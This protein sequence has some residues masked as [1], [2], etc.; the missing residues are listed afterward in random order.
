MQLTND[1]VAALRRAVAW[2]KGFARREPQLVV[3]PTPMP[4]EGTPDWIELAQRLAAEAQYTTLGLKP[5]QTEPVHVVDNGHVDPSGWAN[6][7]DEVALRRKMLALG[8]SLFE[9]DV[10]A[11]IARA[12]H[13]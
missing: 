5:W 10:P 3:F 13:R 11:A 4:D 7:P 9:P 6:R 1:D 12:E 2:G 8:I